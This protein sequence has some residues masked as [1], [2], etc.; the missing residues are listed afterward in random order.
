[1]RFRLVMNPMLTLN[2][3]CNGGI[4]METKR[5]WHVE[6]MDSIIFYSIPSIRIR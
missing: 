2:V 3:E 4:M 5:S 6:R 1:M